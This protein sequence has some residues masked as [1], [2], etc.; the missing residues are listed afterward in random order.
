MT[1]QS[2]VA[3]MLGFGSPEDNPGRPKYVHEIALTIMIILKAE[4]LE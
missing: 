1:G 2:H 4:A 3:I